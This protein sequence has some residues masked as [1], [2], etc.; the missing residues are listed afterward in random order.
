MK[1]AAIAMFPALLSIATMVAAAEPTLADVHASKQV[2]CASC[3][4]GKPGSEVKTEKCMACHGN[5]DK[6]VL[7]T[8]KNE[9]NPHESHLGEPDCSQ[10][11]HAHKKSEAVCNQCHDFSIKMKH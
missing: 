9:V 11:H 8:D 10:C 3:H 5:Y 4:E 7:L 2:A 6:L 1:F